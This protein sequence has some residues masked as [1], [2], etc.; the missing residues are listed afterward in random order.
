MF[1]FFNRSTSKDYQQAAEETY[2]VPT[3]NV[4]SVKVPPKH[5]YSVGIDDEGDTVLKL[6]SGNTTMS[7]TLSPSGV[8]RIIRLLEATIPESGDDWK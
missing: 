7:M 4:D 5:D 1:D 6:H 2:N 8:R 3:P